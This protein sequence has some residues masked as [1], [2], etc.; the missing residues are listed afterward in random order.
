MYGTL[1]NVKECKVGKYSEHEKK[2]AVSV[3]S[4]LCVLSVTFH[5]TSPHIPDS[6][7]VPVSAGKG[8]GSMELQRENWSHVVALESMLENLVCKYYF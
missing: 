7:V 8:M 2:Q 3:L 6:W 1:K 4:T 5:L